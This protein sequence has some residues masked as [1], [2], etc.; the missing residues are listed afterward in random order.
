MTHSILHDKT[1][2]SRF[3]EVHYY[4]NIYNNRK[5][6][7]IKVTNYINIK[8][9]IYCSNCAIAYVIVRTL[10]QCYIK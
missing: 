6:E 4:I 1:G 5:H 8:K 10:I 9:V 7:I 2:S 3:T